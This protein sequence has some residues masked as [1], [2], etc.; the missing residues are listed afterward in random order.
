MMFALPCSTDECSGDAAGGRATCDTCHDRNGYPADWSRSKD[1]AW[2]DYRPCPE[3]ERIPVPGPGCN[4]H[5]VTPQPAS[6][7]PCQERIAA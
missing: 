5:P 6:C 1:D 2:L 3:I 4:T 7:Q